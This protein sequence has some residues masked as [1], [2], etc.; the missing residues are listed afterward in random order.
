M[1]A[2]PQNL[3]SG[4]AD[5]ILDEDRDSLHT[6]PIVILPLKTNVFRR[7]RMVKNSRLESAIEFLMSRVFTG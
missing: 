6:I 3:D 7:A 2:Q 4:E 1:N 5:V